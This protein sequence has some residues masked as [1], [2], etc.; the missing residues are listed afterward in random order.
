MNALVV[1][2]IVWKART[3][4]GKEGKRMRDF[5]SRFVVVEMLRSALI[6]LM[7]VA[8]SFSG[9]DLGREL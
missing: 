2:L 7:L 6:S 4:C 3:N 8:H 5:R 1:L 9:G